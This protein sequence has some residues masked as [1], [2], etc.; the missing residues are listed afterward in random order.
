MK[1]FFFRSIVIF[2]LAVFTLAIGIVSVIRAASPLTN[3]DLT[4][5][6]K[7][8]LAR[9]T[10]DKCRSVYDASTW[11]Q[12][13]QCFLSCKEE[14]KAT[15]VQVPN[16]GTKPGTKMVL[17]PAGKVLIFSIDGESDSISVRGHREWTQAKVGMLL[18]QGHEIAASPD[19][20]A[21]LLFPDGSTVRVEATTQIK[22]AAYFTKGGIV[23]AEILLAVG[24]VAAA[25]KK[26]QAV[27]SD[28][29]IRSPNAGASVRGTTFSVSYDKDVK[30]T[31]IAVEEGIVGVT[32]QKP[33]Y[34]FWKKPMTAEVEAGQK[35][36]VSKNEKIKVETLYVR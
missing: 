20:D 32:A 15:P 10:S 24:K 18:E 19:G 31:V 29:K 12:Y 3:V 35:A 28:F 1:N 13:T 9:C 21:V 14:A 26:E 4:E 6:Q 34:K 33:W 27:R 22:I 7:A 23:Q 30:E 16:F 25:V 8:A 5:P 2:F 11:D 17:P 36:T